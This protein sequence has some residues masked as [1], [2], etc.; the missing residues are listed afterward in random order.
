MLHLGLGAFHRAHQAVYLQRLHDAGDRGW[1]LAA[2]NLRRD[3][4]AVLAALIAQRGAY[5]LETVSP[6]GRRQYRRIA[7][8]EHV[9][10]AEGGA[11]ALVALGADPAT[12]IVSLTITE[13]G[14]G[15]DARGELDLGAADIAAD[16]QATREHRPG[17]TVYGVLAAL[18]RERRVRQAGPLTLLSCDNLRHNGARLRAALG[19]YLQAAG[20]GASCDWMHAHT[21][22]PNTMVD[23]I[24]PRPMADL[25]ERV[26][27]A[28]GLDDAAPVSAEEHLQWVVEDRFATGRPA[29][30]AVGAEL[31]DDVEPYEEAKIRLLNAT[32]SAVAWAGALRGHAWIH[33][34]MADPQVR[35]LAQ[36]YASTDAI[37]VL[38]PSPVDL[39]AYLAQVLRRFGNPAIADTV[40]RVA[41]DSRAKLTMFVAP[42]VRDRLTRGEPVDAVAMLPALYL[43]FLERARRGA[44]PFRYD[45]PDAQAPAA[46]DA[47]A[48]L[49]HDAGV[50]GEAAGD[51]RWVTAVR[52]AQPRVPRA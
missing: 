17:S 15:L 33:E 35:R 24:T 4:D 23:R 32:H 13:S 21:T 8:I 39:D 14:Y 50:W 41:G 20:D 46:A 27:T 30:E 47:V 51:P 40:Q 18:L 52:R 37:P 25:R 5:T 38:R 36:D 29:W 28:T 2:G 1:R 7:S 45:E 44:L 9:V 19:R 6:E 48:V 49:C 31:V 34:A 26:R 42:T 16:L 43:A 22:C 3:G 11:E 12:R 10:P